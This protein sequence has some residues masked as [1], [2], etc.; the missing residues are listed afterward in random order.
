[1]NNHLNTL[2]H[3]RRAGHAKGFTLVEMLVAIGIVAFLVVGI[4]QIF[5]SVGGLVSVGTAVSEVD[6][7]A[8]AIERQMRDDFEALSATLSEDTFIAIRMR[9]I[10][11]VNRNGTLDS[12]EVAVYL[13]QEDRDADIR[14]MGDG[15]F[16]QPYE[17]GSRAVTRRLDEIAF[18]VNPTVAGRGGY[19]SF[20][21]DRF[22]SNAPQATSQAS[23]IYYGQALRPPR[24]PNWPPESGMANPPR[25]PQRIFLPDGDFGEGVPRFDVGADTEKNRFYTQLGEEYVGTPDDFQNATGRNANA[26]E[27]ILA[28]QALVL[29]GGEASGSGGT[30]PGPTIAAGPDNERE[31]ALYIRDTETIHRLWLP[32]FYQRDHQGPAVGDFDAQSSART[33]PPAPR[34]IMHGRTDVCAQSFDDVRRWLEGDPFRQGGIPNLRDHQS[35]PFLEGRFAIGLEQDPYQADPLST[36]IFGNLNNVPNST[37]PP[38]RSMLWMHAD[39]TSSDAFHVNRRS[40]RAAIAGTI[41]RLLMDDEPPLIDRQRDLMSIQYDI[42]NFEDPI[43]PED[44]FMD[45]HA[46]L[47][48]RCSN[49]EIAWRLADPDWPVATRN[50]DIDS[51]GV[52][53]YRTGDRVWIDITPLDPDNPETTRSTI[54]NWIGVDGFSGTII[55]SNAQQMLGP[56]QFGGV[57]Q[58]SANIISDGALQPE[59]GYEDWSAVSGGNLFI[60]QFNNA[61]KYG[62]ITVGDTFGGPFPMP[63]Y[64]PDLTGGAPQGAKEYLA[65]WPFHAPDPAGNG[66]NQVFPKKIQ[67]RVRMTLHDQQRRIPGGKNFEYI[68]DVSPEG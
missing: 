14:D 41:T 63:L 22:E 65:I 37:N 21:L 24:D 18:L 19:A 25:V 28:R 58:G 51:D 64:N 68:F 57:P 45:S 15:L 11:D 29:V 49:F 40:I 44:A 59:I 48:E 43:D 55:G 62:K 16:N 46:I 10:G 32:E 42:Q 13:S 38:V 66:F 9:E 2:D 52:F 4:G 20:Q 53:E 8:R 47:A 6:Q 5:R 61:V 50:I 3:T 30:P 60:D 31:Y 7:M 1:M 35:A 39:P 12:N 67:I 34:L 23:R 27:W 54:R 26:G 36:N 17:A 56:V 33:F